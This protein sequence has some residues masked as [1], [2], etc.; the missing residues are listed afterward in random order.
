MD[1]EAGGLDVE[2]IQAAIRQLYTAGVFWSV[3]VRSFGLAEILSALM[4]SPTGRRIIAHGAPGWSLSL[5]RKW[6]N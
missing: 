6:P 1:L 3:R 2:R 5:L 4:F